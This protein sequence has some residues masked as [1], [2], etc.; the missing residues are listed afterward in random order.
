MEDWVAEFG[1]FE[2]APFIKNLIFKDSKKGVHFIIMEWQTKINE[3][4]W[5]KLG[6][7]KSNV[8]LANEDV[9]A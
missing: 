3:T 6:S 8:R 1:K 7:K 9:L 4:F 5:T 2:N